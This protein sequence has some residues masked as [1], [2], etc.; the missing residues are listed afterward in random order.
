MQ[1]HCNWVWLYNSMKTFWVGKS[2]IKATEF[3]DNLST[4]EP[5]EYSSQTEK[6]VNS[7]HRL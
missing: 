3:S 2:M 7:K 5:A 4:N 6:V 1:I